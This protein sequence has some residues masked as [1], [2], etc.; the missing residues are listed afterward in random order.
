MTRTH[1][2]FIIF[3]ESVSGLTRI[4]WSLPSHL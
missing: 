2:T 3:N 4:L 1:R